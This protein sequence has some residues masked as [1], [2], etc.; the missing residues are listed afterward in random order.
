MPRRMVALGVGGGCGAGCLAG[1]GLVG[2]F[3][4]Q[5]FI[6]VDGGAL[7]IAKVRWRVSSLDRRPLS[8]RRS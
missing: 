3:D 8:S 2:V 7:V 4:T 5:L 1:G 6:V